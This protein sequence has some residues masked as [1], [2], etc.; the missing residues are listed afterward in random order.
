M[1]T[2]DPRA[3]EPL[4]AADA[5]GRLPLARWA[6]I[7]DNP[8][9]SRT[10]SLPCEDLEHP[11]GAKLE[12]VALEPRAGG[13]FLIRIPRRDAE[14]LARVR[15]ISERELRG[16]YTTCAAALGHSAKAIREG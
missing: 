8:D 6:D 15:R 11:P 9:G 2:P 14:G 7:T 5:S 10:Y 12:V 1:A 13:G 3:P 4:Q 16:L